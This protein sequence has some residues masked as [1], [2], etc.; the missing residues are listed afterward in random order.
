MR[1]KPSAWV[2]EELAEIIKLIKKQKCRCDNNNFLLSIGTRLCMLEQS[3]TLLLQKK[4][5]D[6]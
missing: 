2:L 6:E 5:E 4:K 1:P 3:L